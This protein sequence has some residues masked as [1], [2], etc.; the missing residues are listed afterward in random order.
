M[1]KVNDGSGNAVDAEKM[2]E[3]LKGQKEDLDVK[4]KDIVIED[5]NRLKHNALWEA[6]ELNDSAKVI[7]YLEQYE[8]N[9]GEE[10]KEAELYD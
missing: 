7:A 5:K 4:D 3:S 9:S 6:V 2:K 8:E 10:L 1:L